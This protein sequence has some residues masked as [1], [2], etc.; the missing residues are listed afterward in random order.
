MDWTWSPTSAEVAPLLDVVGAEKGR[1]RKR[2]LN[3]QQEEGE[4]QQWR[5][6]SVFIFNFTTKRNVLK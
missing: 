1:R 6:K 2:S 5:G 3:S 4:P